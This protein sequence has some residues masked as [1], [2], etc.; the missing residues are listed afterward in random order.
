MDSGRIIRDEEMENTF[1]LISIKL[2]IYI[3]IH[4]IYALFRIIKYGVQGFKRNS[5]LSVTTIVVMT[6]TLLVLSA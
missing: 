5:W 1:W 2:T 3:N 6:L 4:Y